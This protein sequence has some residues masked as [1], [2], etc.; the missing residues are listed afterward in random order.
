MDA[1]RTTTAT[2]LL[3]DDDATSCL[4]NQQRLEDDG[5]SVVTA[6]DRTEGLGRARQ[7]A[8]NRIFIHLGANGAGSLSFIEALRSDDACRHIPVVVLGGQP[9][10][11]ARPTKLRTVNR[12][13]W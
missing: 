1:V 10:V 7:S 9:V 8:P 13:L 6:R 5:Y 2:A 3:V 11:R 12:D 4:A